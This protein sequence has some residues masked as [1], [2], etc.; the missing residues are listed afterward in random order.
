[1]NGASAAIYTKNS[2]LLSRTRAYTQSWKTWRL[3]H[4]HSYSRAD[5]AAGARNCTSAK[6][7]N[8]PPSVG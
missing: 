4:V 1:M 7:R 3:E 8:S 2:R 6:S 5:V